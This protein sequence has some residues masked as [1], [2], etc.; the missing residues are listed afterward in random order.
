MSILGAEG[1]WDLWVKQLDTGPL[2]RLT[3]E[4]FQNLK[5]TWS[6]DGRSLTFISSRSTGPGDFNV[7]TKRADGSDTAELVLNR[8]Q[9]IFEPIYSPDGTWLV[10]REGSVGFGVGDIYAIRPELDSIAVP[11][12]VTEFIAHS[13]ALSPNG[14]WLAYVSNE[15]GR[16]EIYVRPFPDAGASRSQVST[17]GGTEPVWAHS[18]RELFYRSASDELV[19]TQV[20]TE[21]PNFTPGQQTVLFSMANYLSGV[22]DQQYDVSS[23]D[24]RFVMLRVDE[25]NSQGELILVENW[26][27]ELRQQVPN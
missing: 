22:N 8:E 9:P 6:R 10:F 16:E 20:I 11:L 23:D 17:D 7:W 14:R 19:A 1:T 2:T 26:F 25:E 21:D 3:F 15:S 4:G 12:V 13:F 27:E 18:G 5:P 24:Q